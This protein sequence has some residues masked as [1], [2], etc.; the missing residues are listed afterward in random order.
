MVEKGGI[1]I[2]LFLSIPSHAPYM[3][4]SQEKSRIALKGWN[5]DGIKNEDERIK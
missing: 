2:S 4:G 1:R 5:E 3:A